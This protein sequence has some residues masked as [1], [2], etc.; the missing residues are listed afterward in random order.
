MIV[1]N[2]VIVVSQ[3]RHARGRPRL[4]LSYVENVQC[5][6]IVGMTASSQACISTRKNSSSPN[7]LHAPSIASSRGPPRYPRLPGVSVPPQEPKSE[8]C[9]NSQQLNLRKYGHTNTP[10][11]RRIACEKHNIPSIRL[12][13]VANNAKSHGAKEAVVEDI[14][15]ALLLSL[16][17]GLH[18]KE[19]SGRRVVRV[20]VCVAALARGS[21]RDLALLL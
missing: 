7:A 16:L 2:I 11:H 3:K 12:E 13:P 15:P 9:A 8:C 14:L 5:S 10:I 21:G 4:S 1:Q 18:A 19:P 17:A 20:P 6:P